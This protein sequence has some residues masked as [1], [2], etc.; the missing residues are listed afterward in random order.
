MAWPLSQDYNEAV[1]NPAASF[2]DPELRE[3]HAVADAH[4]RPAPHSGNCADVYEIHCP[5]TQSRWAVKCFTREVP[6]LRDRY[7]A[8]RRHLTHANLSWTV[9]CTY[10]D[11]GI[12]VRGQWFPVLV[13]RW[14]DGRLL[15]E[16]VRAALDQPALLAALNQGWLRMGRALREAR[17]AHGDLQHGNVLVVPGSPT[18]PPAVKLVDYD[19][20]V[21]PDLAKHQPGEVGHP[22]YQHPQRREAMYRADVDRFPLLL[23]ATALHCQATGGRALWDR[24]DNGDNLLFREADLQA[25]AASSLFQELWQLDDPVAHFLVGHLALASQGTLD[26]VPLVDELLAGGRAP[27]A[28]Q[29]DAHQEERL[30]AW[31]GSRRA[32]PSTVGRLS[33]SPVVAVA[34]AV[35]D[36]SLDF[37]ASSPAVAST[38]RRRKKAAGESVQRRP[39]GWVKAAAAA[40]VLTAVLGVAIGIAARR[41]SDIHSDGPVAALKPAG[42]DSKAPPTNRSAPPRDTKATEPPPESAQEKPAAPPEVAQPAQP[43][44]RMPVLKQTAVVR[45]AGDAGAPYEERPEP[46]S[47]LVGFHFMIAD[48]DIFIQTVQPIFLTS[49]GRVDG[50]VHGD[51]GEKRVTVEARPGYA[52]SA[53]LV[54]LKPHDLK[55]QFMRVSPSRETALDPQEKY[56]SP[57]VLG[58]GNQDAV[59]LASDGS[60]VVGIFGNYG[61][62]TDSLGLIML[63]KEP[64]NAE[65]ARRLPREKATPAADVQKLATRAPVPAREALAAAEKTVRERHRAVYARRQPAELRALAAQL[66]Q[67]GL[68][69]TDPPELRYVQL[70]EARDLAADAGDPGLALT[71]IGE[72][73]KLHAIDVWEMKTAAMERLGQA[74]T[75]PSAAQPVIGA[76]AV[77]EQVL[78]LEEEALAADRFEVIPRLLKAAEAALPRTAN[79][80][81]RARIQARG[82]E[83]DA[84][85]VEYD[86]V[87]SAVAQLARNPDD[88]KANHA[89]GKYCCLVKGDW[90]R[91]LP[92]LVLGR[93]PPWEQAA[94]KDLATQDKPQEQVEVGDGWWNLAASETR[95]ARK[96]L[97]WR[98]YCWYK[99]AEAELNPMNRARVVQRLAQ[100]AQEAPELEVVG[101]I[102]TLPGHQENIPGVAFAPD[103]HR[104]LS[105]GE[106]KT[107]RLWTLDAGKMQQ[108]T[109]TVGLGKVVFTPDGRQALFTQETML[110]LWD[111]QT[112]QP[113]RA[114]PGHAGGILSLALSTDGKYALTGSPDKTARLWV[115]GTGKL[116]KEFKGHTD[117]VHAV[118]LSPDGRRVLT[119]S[120]DGTIRLWD[121]GTGKQV[122]RFDGEPGQV[123][124]LG[125][126]PDGRLALSGENELL[127]RLWDVATGQEVRQFVGHTDT[128]RR[129]I[130]SAD[131]RRCLSGSYDQT[132]RLWDV[133]T[134][135]QLCRLEGSAGSI[136]D[137]AL[138][139]DGRRALSG[140]KDGALCLWGLPRW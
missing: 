9:D 134:G 114:F 117:I 109:S 119:G 60:L 31:F 115:V 23:V 17:I 24:Y 132:V 84:W 135:N 29:L 140:G 111:L 107:L 99:R 55:L 108:F 98:A 66:L 14:I 101:L 15:H 81:L 77:V 54:C 47:L 21:V 88:P 12:R 125:F 82:K 126:S 90:T 5:A 18:A 128:V 130:F 40:A 120:W 3:G 67:E 69:T 133:A 33:P 26:Q 73:N 96:R 20:M 2:S 41:G 76:A 44:P 72:L 65:F 53:V 70:R 139:P 46:L 61:A 131:G 63:A 85:R 112:W 87:R 94:R 13:M 113:V 22:A 137:V 36:S 49:K 103:G 25:P 57:W 27:V 64:A 52:V 48:D 35:P 92:M 123:T 32:S 74:T 71:A 127:V 110:V 1:R 89:L 68:A 105:A 30:T 75:S 10:L 121:A 124:C 59:V 45:I 78:A 80:L 102:R 51:P 116:Q 6:G 19:G 83:A 118:A 56:T 136:E 97:Q 34:A 42:E 4:G 100:T 39:A 62:F 95:L 16:F 7:A 37:T 79:A 91:G 106:D 43:A 28:A 58:R 122:R 138:S 93:D 38:V 8:I 50:H 11:Q 129:V 104:A 86:R